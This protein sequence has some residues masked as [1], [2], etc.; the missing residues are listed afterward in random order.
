M[1]GKLYDEDFVEWAQETARLL[2]SGSFDQIDVEHLVEEVEG[3]ASRDRREVWSRLR[4]LVLHLLKWRWQPEKRCSDWKV[5]I[6][7]ERQELDLLFEQSPSLKRTAGESLADAYPVAVELASIETDLPEES[8]PSECLFSVE[9][10]LDH[11]F[12]P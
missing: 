8:F 3:L 12:L 9:Q 2:R 5:A 11:D 1:D 6:I 4:V 7:H 10:T